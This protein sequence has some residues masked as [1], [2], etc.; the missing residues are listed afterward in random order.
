MQTLQDKLSGD[1]G[2][3]GEP[4]D[5]QQSH[6]QARHQVAARDAK[7]RRADDVKRPAGLHSQHRRRVVV[8]SETKQAC[9]QKP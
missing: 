5:L 8:K 1:G 3:N 6:H 7:R 9:N 4:S 2:G